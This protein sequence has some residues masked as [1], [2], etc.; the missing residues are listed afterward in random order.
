MKNIYKKL[1]VNSRRAAA[2]RGQELDP[3]SR[4]RN[5]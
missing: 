2:R 5:A 3:F 1:D 4:M